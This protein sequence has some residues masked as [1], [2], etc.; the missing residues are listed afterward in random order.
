M[1]TPKVNVFE[2]LLKINQAKNDLLK[3]H[4]GYPEDSEFNNT[5]DLVEAMV[6]GPADLEEALERHGLAHLETDE[7][8]DMINQRI[9]HFYGLGKP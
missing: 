4:Q 1:T 5:I 3:I 2:C 6:R 9:K 8:I 7:I